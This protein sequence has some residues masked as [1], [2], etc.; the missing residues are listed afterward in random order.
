M[1]DQ[2]TVEVLSEPAAAT[3]PAA[4]H[5]TD[6]YEFT[7]KF[8]PDKKKPIFRVSQIAAMNA[9]G[10]ATENIVVQKMR[11]KRKRKP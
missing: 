10:A 4:E 1:T 9:F 7:F 3:P 5:R 6:F 8:G 2:S 11:A